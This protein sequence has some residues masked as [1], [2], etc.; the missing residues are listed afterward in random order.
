MFLF[1]QG[2]T[3]CPWLLRG[4]SVRHA[5]AVCHK[6]FT[7]VIISQMFLF[8]EGSAQARFETF[9]TARSAPHVPSKNLVRVPDQNVRVRVPTVSYE[10]W[11]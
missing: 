11:V 6:F 7:H 4:C 2:S 10:Y 8:V 5:F 9:V 3:W 1:V